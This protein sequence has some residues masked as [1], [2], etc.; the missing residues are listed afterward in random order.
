[1][2]VLGRKSSL[3]HSVTAFGESRALMAERVCKGKLRPHISWLPKGR[4]ATLSMPPRQMALGKQD[5]Q[6]D[7]KIN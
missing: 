3:K 4:D 5:R 7:T 1:M 2:R 6:E